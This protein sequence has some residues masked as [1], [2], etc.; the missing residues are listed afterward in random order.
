MSLMCS[1]DCDSYVTVPEDLVTCEGT[2]F[3][4]ECSAMIY[5]GT[6]YYRVLLWEEPDWEDN[7]YC[8]EEVHK[9]VIPCCETC[10]D[11]AASYLALGFC[12]TFGDLRN[13]IQE[14]NDAVY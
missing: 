10:G 12:W 14:M 3:C 7:P 9:A 6:P 13:D 11:L 1:T 5:P 4:R 2:L 8:S